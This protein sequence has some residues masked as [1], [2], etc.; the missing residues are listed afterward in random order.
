MPTRFWAI[1]D[2]HLSFAKPKNMA[3]FGDKWVNHEETLKAHWSALI[4][5]D[6]VVLVAG[7][8]S[9]ADSPN[10]AVPD[11][12]WLGALSG[13]KILL[14]GNHDHWWKSIEA[15]RRVAEPLGLMLL[16]GDS[17]AIEGVLIAGAMGHIAPQDPYY[18]A[19]PP[20]NRYER[21][22]ARLEAALRHATEART[23]GQTLLLMMHYPPFTSDAQPTAFSE[24]I[25][26]FQPTQCIY[27]HLHRAAEWEIAVQGVRDGVQFQLVAADYVGMTPQL[28]YEG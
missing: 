27:G 3:R 1:A 26:Q 16:E 6:D 22:L 25:R 21:E 24:L 23:V 17:I 18:K 20:K 28:I 15:A 5:P 8:I 14:R 2:T 7:D 13:K 4:Q 19:D 12:A 10:K 11:L 9:W